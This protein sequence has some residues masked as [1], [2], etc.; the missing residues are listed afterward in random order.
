MIKNKK[1]GNFSS[2]SK[3]A[4]V[5]KN[6]ANSVLVQAEEETVE[7]IRTLCDAISSEINDSISRLES[8]IKENCSSDADA[9]I[10][11]ITKKLSSIEDKLDDISSNVSS[12]KTSV[13]LIKCQLSSNNNIAKNGAKK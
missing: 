1:N 6:S 7:I 2:A 5:A 11:K 10:K 12:L 8:S 4:A 9:E 13:E 3:N